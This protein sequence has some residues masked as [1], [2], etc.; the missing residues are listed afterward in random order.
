MNTISYQK[1]PQYQKQIVLQKM[2]CLEFD[3]IISHQFE[4]HKIFPTTVGMLV[5][6]CPRLSLVQ[7]KW[8]I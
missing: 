6:A 2:R 5:E 3:E 1:H 7:R 8:L 4:T